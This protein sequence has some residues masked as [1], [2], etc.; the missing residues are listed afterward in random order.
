MLLKESF[1]FVMINENLAERGNNP[2]G[3]G[4]DRKAPDMPPEAMN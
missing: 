2:K 4:G 1:Y 3:F